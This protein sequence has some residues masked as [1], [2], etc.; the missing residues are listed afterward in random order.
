MES[1]L[2]KIRDLKVLVIGDVMLDHYIW[3]DAER[4]SPEAPVPVIDVSIDTYVPGGAA[5]VALNVRQLGGRVT[6]CGSIANDDA[7]EQLLLHFNKA[8]IFYDPRYSRNE[9]STIL[10]TRVVVRGQQMCRL[11]REEA[12]I[13]YRFKT[14]EQW[15]VLD[16]KV[17]EVDL[18]IISDYAKGVVSQEL[19]ERVQ[20]AA[21]GTKTFL[22]IDPKPKSRIQFSGLDLMTPNRS[23]AIAL[24]KLEID[25]HAK[26]PAKDIAAALWQRHGCKNT[27]VTLGSHGML[28]VEMG[29][30]K[31]VIPTVAKEVFDVSGAGDTV[32]AVL[33]MALASGVPLDEACRIANIAAGVVVS[34][35]GTSLVSPGEILEYGLVDESDAFMVG[36]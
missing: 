14:D 10:K 19:I 21:K 27:V 2:S 31:K 3:G 34:K 7:G 6:L 13:N 17:K 20:F 5:N 18:V 23:E 22:A 9:A 8:G 26:F 11:D 24:S 1:I 16:Q 25:P 29:E 32:I 33:S 12:P 30:V 35:V 36:V 15:A 4:I 28:L